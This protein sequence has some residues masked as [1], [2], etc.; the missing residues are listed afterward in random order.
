MV[1]DR[2]ARSLCACAFLL[3]HCSKHKRRL[4]IV[5]GVLVVLVWAG[6]S[7]VWW[8]FYYYGKAY[9]FQTGR[10]KLQTGL[11][12]C[13]CGVSVEIE[14]TPDTFERCSRK[15]SCRRPRGGFRL[16]AV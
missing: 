4:V 16:P 7:A 15:L 5:S 2:T 9:A 14:K 12:A 13:S 10:Q 3:C 1:D 8:T 6:L 11:R